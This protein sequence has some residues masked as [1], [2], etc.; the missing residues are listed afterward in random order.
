MKRWDLLV[1]TS[2]DKKS[3]L[4]S[5]ANEA[6]SVNPYG[7]GKALK[8]NWSRINEL[9][10]DILYGSSSAQIN[11]AYSVLMDIIMSGLSDTE[12]ELVEDYEDW[13]SDYEEED[14]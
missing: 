8:N 4:L 10:V 14:M 12:R 5:M 9:I 2:E 7:F 6:A 3:D 13:N 11:T 1:S